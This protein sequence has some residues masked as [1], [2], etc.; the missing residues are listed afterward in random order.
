MKPIL[1]ITM[2]LF[3]FITILSCDKNDDFDIAFEKETPARWELIATYIEGQDTQYMIETEYGI[4]YN[5]SNDGT[6]ASNHSEGGKFGHFYMEANHLIL[7]YTNTCNLEYRNSET[8]PLTLAKNT[9]I[10]VEGQRYIHKKA[11]SF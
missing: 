7:S 4:H 10:S 3:L 9:V 11:Q 8:K 6:F 5:F 1:N 2:L